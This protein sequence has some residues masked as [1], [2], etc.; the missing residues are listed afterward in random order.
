[1]VLDI[2]VFPQGKKSLF[3]GQH[4]ASDNC[5]SRN[6]C[7]AITSSCNSVTSKDIGD[8]SHTVSHQIFDLLYSLN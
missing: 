7:D 3:H 4:D 6:P 1:M 2:H 8:E 5:I